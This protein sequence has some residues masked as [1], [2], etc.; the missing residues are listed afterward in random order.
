MIA[1]KINVCNSHESPGCVTDIRRC[2]SV[3]RAVPDTRHFPKPE[4]IV[5]VTRNPSDFAGL[6]TVSDLIMACPCDE[7]RPPKLKPVL[8]LAA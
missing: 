8:K 2:S 5:R 4:K 6:H 3:R 7:T 1:H